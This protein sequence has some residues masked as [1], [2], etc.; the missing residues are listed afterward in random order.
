M[1][2]HTNGQQASSL[3]IQTM[4]DILAGRLDS[5]T[6]EEARDL[7]VESVSQANLA[8]YEQNTEGKK[9]RDRMGTTITAALVVEQHAYI[10]NV[11]DSRTYWQSASH[12][13]VR[14]TR[15]HSIVEELV[16]QGHIAEAERYSH[17]ERNQITR[18]LGESKTIEMDAFFVELQTGDRLLLCSDGLWEMIPDQE[19]L[20]RTLADETTEDEQICQIL[21]DA[22]LE[23]GGRDNVTVLVVRAL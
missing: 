4:S 10:V 17:P 8:I 7:L 18:C 16:A 3:A 14:V 15:D 6:E 19:F 21:L 5:T 20:A 13:L 1:G 11:G 12:G 9:E 22:A 23:A 2:G